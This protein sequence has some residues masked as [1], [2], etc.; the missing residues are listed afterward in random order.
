M[1]NTTMT[2]TFRHDHPEY[3]RIASHIERARAE[4]ALAVGEAIGDALV[5]I[6][7]VARNWRAPLQVRSRKP[8]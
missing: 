4:H 8:A 6:V 7:N 2:S 3:A 5:A 1:E